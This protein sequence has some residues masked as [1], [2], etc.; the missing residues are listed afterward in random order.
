MTAPGSALERCVGDP[1]RF[2]EEL[3]CQAPS[4]RTGPADRFGDLLTLRDVDHL[5]TGTLLRQPAFRLV[6][7]GQP[8]DPKSYTQT[9]RI[10]GA[11]VGRTARPDR[12]LD[13][14]ADGATIV[15]QALHR[16]WPPVAALCRELE[17]ELTH[18]VQANAYVTPATS[19]GFAVHH[20]THDVFVIQTH[21]HKEWRVYPPV[22]EL[23]GKEQPWSR[24]LGDPGRPVLEAELSP[25]HCLYIPRGFPHDAVARE[26][27][28]IH[29]TIGILAYTW[30][31]LWRR[32]LRDISEDVRFRE[33]LPVGFARDPGG[34][35]AEIGVRAKD[36]QAWVEEA[37]TPG[38]AEG[39]AERFWRTRRAVLP[40]GLIQ[41]EEL[42][43]LGPDARFRR[44]PGSVFRVSVEGDQ[45]SVL[46]GSRV[47]RMPSFVEPA[48]RFIAGREEHFGV[49][50]VP[51]ALD[52]DSRLILLRRLVREG[53]LEVK[54][55]AG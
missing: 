22:V 5:V 49:G 32:I 53:A 4:L 40:G 19:Q 12:V 34:I 44:R 28:S 11:P 20:D 9:I 50:D 42:R 25:G 29:V 27:V 17:L 15:L 2:A 39:F 33:S 8:L 55:A 30:V 7:E 3:W 48:L 52:P 45:A 18:P 16:Q 43:R 38:A 23:A 35:A 13:H 26:E 51:G 10:G 47:L 54:G 6:K 31:D 37:A 36:L 24:E 14:F 1:R 41:L 21:G 46:L